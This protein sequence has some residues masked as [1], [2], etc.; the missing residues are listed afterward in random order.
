MQWLHDHYGV[1]KD[2]ASPAVASLGLLLTLG[3][4]FFGFR[5]FNRWKREKLEENRIGVALTALALAYESTIIFDEVRAPLRQEFEWKDM[6]QV[7]EPSDRRRARGS[8][9]AVLK[10]LDHRKDF[11]DRLWQ[12]QPKFMAVF[13]PQ[14]EAIFSKLHGARRQIEISAEA[15]MDELRIEH[16]PDDE[17]MREFRRQL[18]V[19]TSCPPGEA[20][21]SGDRVGKQVHQFRSEIEALSRPIVDRGFRAPR[22]SGLRTQT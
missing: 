11:F 6:P 7:A 3:I 10:R 8:Q 20:G 13:G 1:L 16:D 5:T 21:K 18:R 22:R 12:L 4:A 19:D 17:Q 14:T 15:L 9:F 2:F